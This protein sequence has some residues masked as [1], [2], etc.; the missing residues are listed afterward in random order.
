MYGVRLSNDQSLIATVD[1]TGSIRFFDREL[2]P[3]SVINDAGS[4]SYGALHFSRNDLW[5]GV[6]NADGVRVFDVES[7]R[8]LW[9]GRDHQKPLYAVNFG[10]RDRTILSGGTDGVCYLWDLQADFGS[11]EWD[12]E[13]LFSVLIRQEGRP[14]YAA[15]RQLAQTPEQTTALLTRKLAEIIKHPVSDSDVRRSI[16]ALGAPS[17]KIAERARTQLLDLGMAIYDQLSKHLEA[18]N[19]TERKRLMVKDLMRRISGR[20]RRVV[21]LLADL[22]TQ[23]ADMSIDQLLQASRPGKLNG[24]LKEAKKRRESML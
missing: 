1:R 18:G 11:E 8:A 12:P 4:F 22:E 3:V 13:R 5:V 7:G 15:Y 21:A 17:R 16:V 2:N 9:T 6:G 10:A 20:T 24:M 19:L 14:A 23:V